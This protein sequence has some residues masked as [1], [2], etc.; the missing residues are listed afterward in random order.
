MQ[1]SCTVAGDVVVPESVN[2]GVPFVIA[3]PRSRVALDIRQL[4]DFVM[5]DAPA[6]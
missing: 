4:A 6:I 2:R 5:A 1:P 3:A